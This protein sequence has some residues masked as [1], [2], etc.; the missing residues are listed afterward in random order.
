MSNSSAN[1]L[2][3]MQNQL[4]LMQEA[5]RRLESQLVGKSSRVGEVG[6]SGVHGGSLDASG[7]FHGSRNTRA[8]SSLGIHT[9]LSKKNDM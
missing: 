2:R 9:V 8:P 4:T 5:I 1:E 6:G 3:D 7:G